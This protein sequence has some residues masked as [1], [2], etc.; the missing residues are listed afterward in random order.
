MN[1]ILGASKKKSN[2]EI[3]NEVIAGKWGV[4]D[5][6]KQ[7]LTNAGYD[8]NTIQDLVNKK[9]G[10][11]TVQTYTVKS[12][13]RHFIRDSTKNMELHIKK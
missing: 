4:G 6:R 3:A 13:G 10:A 7:A 8:Y 12:G 1:E 5:T 9:M 11:S 2:D